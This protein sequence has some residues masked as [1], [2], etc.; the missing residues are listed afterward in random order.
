MSPV[1]EEKIVA[2]LEVI[3][4][5]LVGKVTNW[6]PKKILEVLTGLSSKSI[7]NLSCGKNKKIIKKGNL[8]SYRSYLEY[9]EIR[10]ARAEGGAQ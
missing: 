3:E 1:M 10:E 7:D 5:L 6:V 2:R 9:C 4:G 8:Y